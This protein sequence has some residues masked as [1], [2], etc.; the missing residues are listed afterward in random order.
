MKRNAGWK[1]K[2]RFWAAPWL[3][4]AA[5]LWVGAPVAIDSEAEDVA[6]ESILVEFSASAP[7]PGNGDT[8]RPGGGIADIAARILSRLEPEIRVSARVFEFLPV[9]A[10]EADAEAMMQLIAMPEV[11]AIQ[12]DRALEL[13][14]SLEDT[15][16]PADS[17]EITVPEMSDEI[18]L[19]DTS[20]EVR[21]PEVPEESAEQATDAEPSAQEE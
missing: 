2:V 15:G 21:I 10:L 14:P 6:R 4:I 20:D 8:V 7:A 11:L 18:A 13:L 12:P 9:I 3:L 19:P 16:V 1:Q 17:A 5:A